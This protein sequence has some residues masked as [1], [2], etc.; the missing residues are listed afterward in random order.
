MDEPVRA[1]GRYRNNGELIAAA[2]ALGHLSVDWLV[3]DVTY[4]KGTFWRVFRP[5]RLVASDL[6]PQAGHRCDTLDAT[7]LPYTDGLFDAVAV[8]APY[9]LNGTDRG[10][11]ARYGVDR[12]AGP[13]ERHKLMRAMLG[14]A[15]RVTRP[16][17]RVLFKCQDQVCNGQLHWQTF[18]AYEWAGE[19]GLELVEKL[20]YAGGRPQPARTRRRCLACG[21]PKVPPAHRCGAVRD[22]LSRLSVAD[23]TVE[24]IGSETP[25][26]EEYPSPQEHAYYRP[27]SL[28][29][30]RKE[31]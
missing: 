19:V 3:A 21:R 6:Y 2:A 30:F 17:G 27:S 1:V 7:D 10:E 18:M 26:L 29:I 14:E 31:T 28:L 20:D 25:W 5:E 9:K 13:P 11:G 4:G 8:D 22:W 12:Y 16:Y 23:L 15:A 24:V